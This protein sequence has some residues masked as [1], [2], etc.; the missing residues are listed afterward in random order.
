MGQSL[1]ACGQLQPQ[2]RRDVFKARAQHVMQQQHGP[3]VRWQFVQCGKEGLPDPLTG[4][5][6]CCA[7]RG[8]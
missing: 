5:A 7:V 4:G 3:H 1:A 8:G 2:Q 6:G